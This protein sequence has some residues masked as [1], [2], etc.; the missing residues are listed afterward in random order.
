MFHA[1][2]QAELKDIDQAHTDKADEYLAAAL[3]QL[4]LAL[5]NDEVRK[6]LCERI[7][8][9]LVPGL[10]TREFET[11]LN[12]ASI[13]R[14][15][16][17]A[18]RE[19]LANYSSAALCDDTQVGLILFIHPHRQDACAILDAIAAGIVVAL[20]GSSPQ[21]F[22]FLEKTLGDPP[23]V[24]TFNT[25]KEALHIIQEFDSDPTAV[26]SRW[27]PAMQHVLDNHLWT[28]RL[29]ALLQVCKGE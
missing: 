21:D 7:R 14:E 20:R 3:K 8:N 15:F 1:A 17:G 18:A 4:G 22:D 24:R 2:E 29:D 28:H 26:R 6:G 5:H 19:G 25:R 10:L 16:T 12:Q 11:F 23:M 9:I 13:E 27:A